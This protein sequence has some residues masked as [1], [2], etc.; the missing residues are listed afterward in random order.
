MP[1]ATSV[2]RARTSCDVEQRAHVANNARL[3][4]GVSAPIYCTGSINVRTG[5]CRRMA[6]YIRAYPARIWTIGVTN[7]ESVFGMR[8]P[9]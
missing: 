7:Q 5:D 4:C 8:T 3:F 9:G 6:L 1:D 2:K